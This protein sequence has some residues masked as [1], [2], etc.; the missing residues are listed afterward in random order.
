MTD[1]AGAPLGVSTASRRVV[2]GTSAAEGFGVGRAL[3]LGHGAASDSTARRS[4]I[5]AIVQ[6]RRD[7]AELLISLP[8]AEAELFAPEAHILDEIEPLLLGRERAGDSPEEIIFASTNCGCTDLVIDL[9]ERLLQALRGADGG[10][11][12]VGHHAGD[13]VLLAESVTPSLVAF[14]PR[15]VVAVV[16]AVDGPM[17]ARRDLG[18]SSHA[19]LLARGRGLPIA[20]VTRADFSSLA[21]GA[22][23]IV[24]ATEPAASLTVGPS[25]R[26]LEAAQERMETAV[27]ERQRG[28]CVP[29]EHLGIALRVNVGSA[30]D[31]I[32]TCADG[33]GLVR[34]EMTFAGSAA[35]P[36]EDEQLAALMRIAI[37]ARGAPIVVRLFDAGG[38]SRS[39][40]S[41][42]AEAHPAASR[43]SSS[44]QKSW[45]PSCEPSRARGDE[46]MCACSCRS[47]RAPRSFG[48]CGPSRTPRCPSAP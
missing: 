32:P 47:S 31:E 26:E 22:W 45:R 2:T 12:A 43:G 18:P 34:T 44:I 25:E 1:I 6:V 11:G 24:D 48:R 8:A 41:A 28:T 9:R 20:Y 37:R 3:K 10:H 4:L 36:S 33:V 19:A 15:Q 17:A 13:L 27:D 46:L 29:L 35:P 21:A 42:A 16:A 39:P 40:G 7:L 23:V 14:L 30:H 5:D 38:E